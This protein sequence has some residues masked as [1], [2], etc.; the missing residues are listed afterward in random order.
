MKWLFPERCS[1]LREREEF[2]VFF[3]PTNDDSFNSFREFPFR[4]NK[5]FGLFSTKTFY[6]IVRILMSPTR[7]RIKVN[8]EEE[9]FGFL[10]D[11]CEKSSCSTFWWT[12][13]RRDRHLIYCSTVCRQEISKKTLYGANKR[14]GKALSPL[15]K[16]D[17]CNSVWISNFF[18]TLKS[19]L[20]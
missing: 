19:V 4:I 14:V 16:K 17:F 13:G 8:S 18:V 3:K 11:S 6:G 9:F 15:E 5:G 10:K 20:H 12:D 1:G 2:S 7:I